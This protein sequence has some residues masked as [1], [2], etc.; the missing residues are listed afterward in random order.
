GRWWRCLALCIERIR[1][2]TGARGEQRRTQQKANR[3]SPGRDAHAPPRRFGFW[4][5]RA[6]HYISSLRRQI[7]PETCTLQNDQGG[8]IPA[9]CRRLVNQTKGF[10][11]LDAVASSWNPAS[12]A[13]P[14]GNY[15]GLFGIRCKW[16]R[17]TIPSKLAT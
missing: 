15:L 3:R 8:R 11:Q 1:K 13:T 12:L 10:W 6:H 9:Y 5:E 16:R 4:I 17:R 14:H 2:L 7:P